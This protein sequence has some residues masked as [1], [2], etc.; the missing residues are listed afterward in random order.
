MTRFTLFSV[1]FRYRFIPVAA[2]AGLARRSRK[3][4]IA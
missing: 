2:A 4:M 1:P 3:V